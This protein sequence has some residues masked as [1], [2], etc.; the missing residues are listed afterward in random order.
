MRK[1]FVLWLLTLAVAG[2]AKRTDNTF[3]VLCYHNVCDKITDT[4]MMNITTAQLIEH[5][6]WLKANNYHVIGIDDIL[7]A[8]KGVRS[9]PDNAVLLTFDDGYESFYTHV[10]PLLKLYGYHAVFALVGSWLDT[11]MDRRFLYGS[12]PKARS[13]L[14]TPEQIREMARSPLVEFASHS[15]NAHYGIT[16]NPQGNKEPFYTSLYF[17]PEANRYENMTDYVTRV[18]TDIRKSKEAVFRYAGYYP[19]VMVWPYGSYNGVVQTLAQKYG[20]PVT[21]TLDDG[22]N[23]PADT[24]ALK[25]ILIS[26]NPSF[27]EFSRAMIEPQEVEKHRALFIDPD[28][29]YAKDSKEADRKL[30]LLIEKVHTMKVTTVVLKAYSD[31]D[32]DGFADM[33]YFPNTQLPL[34]ADLLN[35]IVWQLKSR[36]GVDDIYVR[37]PLYTFEQNDRPMEIADEKSQQKIYRIY[38]ELGA[39]AHFSGIVFDVAFNPQHISKP[40]IYHF[41][42]E[43]YKLLRDF[44][45]HIVKSAALSYTDFMKGNIASLYDGFDNVVVYLDGRLDRDAFLRRVKRLEKGFEKT[46]VCVGLQKGEDLKT[47]ETLAFLLRNGFSSIALRLSLSTLYAKKSLEALKLL[48]LQKSALR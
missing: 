2:Y 4:S 25:R 35:R 34:R 23:T 31:T 3:K 24:G 36:A 7:A 27:E 18:E 17:Y 11:P 45:P 9:L 30:G 1:L 15:Y 6:K 38:H 20:M 10:F 33:L 42:N 29:L 41:A 43:A 8:Q 39:S 37:M 21:M 46:F 16:A 44:S 28:D 48:S 14:L 22:V 13:L 19:R 12:L 32:G 40:V 5:F 26:S 47:E